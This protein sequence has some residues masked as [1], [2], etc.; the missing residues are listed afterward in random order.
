MTV[1]TRIFLPGDLFAV[2]MNIFRDNLHGGGTRTAIGTLSVAG[3]LGFAGNGFIRAANGIGTVTVG[4]DVSGNGT[5]IIP[6]DNA[7]AGS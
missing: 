3:N 2:S 1:P 6:V 4:R 7:A 5:N